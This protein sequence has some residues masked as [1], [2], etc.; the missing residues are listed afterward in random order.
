MGAHACQSQ[1]LRWRR[2]YEAALVEIDLQVIPRRIRIAKKAIHLRIVKLHKVE[3]VEASG[4][5]WTTHCAG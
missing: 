3:D 5:S 1:D 4:R 2:F